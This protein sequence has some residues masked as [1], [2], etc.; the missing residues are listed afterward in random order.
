[1]YLRSNENIQRTLTGF[2]N[3]QIISCVDYFSNDKIGHCH[4]YTYPY[5]MIHYDNLTNNFSGELFKCV[6]T[7]RLFDE[8]PFEHIFFMR[9][10]QAV[11]FLKYL[12]VRNW[13]SQNGKQH[14]ESNDDNQDF[15][16]IEYPHLIRLHLLRI[17]DDYAEQVLLDTKTCYTQFHKRRNTN[18]LF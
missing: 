13:Q 17:H 7:I 11:P 9:I 8:S 14:Q 12:T 1:M 16:I 4:I 5:T 3:H 18:Q 10:S 15:P 6:Q 2:T